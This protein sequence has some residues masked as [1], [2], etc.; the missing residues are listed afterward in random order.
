MRVRPPKSSRPRTKRRPDYS[1]KPLGRV[2]GIDRGRFAVALEGEGDRLVTAVKARELPRASVVIGDLVRLTGDLS[3]REG[4]LARIAQVEER[5]NV[6][7]RSLEEF[8]ESRGEKTIVANA[9]LMVIVVAAASPPPRVGMVDRCLVAAQEAGIPALLCLTKT[10]LSPAEP[11]LEHFA[12][13]DVQVVATQVPEPGQGDDAVAGIDALREMV[14]GKFSVLIGHSGVGKS[15]LI[16]E[17]VE[18]AERAVGAVNAHTGKGRHTSTSAV[19]L[20]LAGGGWIVDT[21]G[22]RS[23]GLGH[24]EVEDVLGVFPGVAEAAELCLPNCGHGT[25]EPGCGI[26]AWAAGEGS[27]EAGVGTG[28]TEGVGVPRK[29]RAERAQALLAAIGAD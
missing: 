18:D 1:Q 7:R 26:A 16:N 13:F 24:V 27:D 29:E 23:F 19:A 17:L 28:G 4:S 2:V 10:D 5:S 14:S 11:F 15:T 8:A 12:G 21:P 3:G 22:V 20:P 25:D 9:D 6:L